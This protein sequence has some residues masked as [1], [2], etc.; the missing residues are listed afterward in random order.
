MRSGVF[1]KQQA[2][3][4]ARTP[5]EADDTEVVVCRLSHRPGRDDRMTTHV[6]LTARALG[7]DRVVFPDN[8]SGPAETVKEVTGRFGGPFEVELNAAPMALL[9]EWRG[10]TAHLTMYGL[11]VQ[12]VEPDIRTA[13]AEAPLL[14]IVGGEKVPFEVYEHADYNVA[15]TNQ[16]HSEIA[17]L[18][19]LLDRLFDGEELDREWTDARRVVV[20]Q[21]TG[22]KVI[23]NDAADRSE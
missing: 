11:P 8:A 22:K 5:M 18:A 3:A 16:P 20:P 9:R 17:G 23:D 12:R 14:V 13:A 4:R 15:V 10:P 6:G 7:A 2:Q 19:V 1:R 21:A